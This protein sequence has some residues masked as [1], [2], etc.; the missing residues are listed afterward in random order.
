MCGVTS[1]DIVVSNSKTVKNFVSFVGK[2]LFLYLIPLFSS[3]FL[4]I[5]G[6]QHSVHIIAKSDEWF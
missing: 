1:A 6:R 3:D 5:H 4:S 2:Y